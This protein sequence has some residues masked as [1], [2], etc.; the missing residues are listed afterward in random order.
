MR[1]VQLTHKQKEVAPA[2]TS[3]LV[4]MNHGKTLKEELSTNPLDQF[5]REVTVV[6]SMGKMVDGA[7][8]GAYESCVMY[9]RT[10]VNVMKSTEDITKEGNGTYSGFHLNKSGLTKE[11]KTDTDY[12]FVVNVKSNT[13]T[14]STTYSLDFGNTD[15]NNPTQQ[16]CF[17]SRQRLPYDAIGVYKFI[18]RTKESFDG[19]AFV[20]RNQLLN[21]STGGQITFNYMVIE[22]IDGM[23]HWDIPYFEGLCDVKMPILRNV[24]KNLLDINKLPIQTGSNICQ[25][26][27]GVVYS[28]P[29]AVYE[30][31]R[32]ILPVE[33]NTT[34]TVSSVGSAD[35]V[36]Q[37]S[38]FYNTS[39]PSLDARIS[40][41]GNERKTVTFTTATHTSLTIS[42]FSALV[43]DLSIR[44]IQLEKESIATTYEDHKTNILRTSEEIVLREVNGVQD[45]YN[46]LIGEYVQRIGLVVHD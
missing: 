46:P 23:E 33:P 38:N 25:I 45:T 15:P 8:D 39:D 11:L 14:G 5:S 2:T 7:R 1:E 34:Y 24:G 37:F 28:R 41:K 3:D 26:I 19:T 32:W 13:L 6:S 22:Y 21:S 10:V 9:G 12:L 27:D 42:L 16:A 4:V 44:N 30:P 31:V 20:S 35:A 18:M 17:T 36:L 43:K 29:T 40:Y